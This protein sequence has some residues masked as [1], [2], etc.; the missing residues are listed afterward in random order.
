MHIYRHFFW[1]NMLTLHFFT[2]EI[3]PEGWMATTFFLRHHRRK[4]GSCP[5]HSPS[6]K[7][8]WR[9]LA[10]F[11]P[12]SFW[13]LGAPFAFGNR[14]RW[15]RL[16]YLQ[17]KVTLLSLVTSVSSHET[18]HQGKAG[19]CRRLRCLSSSMCCRAQLGRSSKLRVERRC[20]LWFQVPDSKQNEFWEDSQMIQSSEILCDIIWSLPKRLFSNYSSL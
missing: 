19:S 18:V 13:C 14:G 2:C 20:L 10:V 4:G 6:S 16:L 1:F 9:R 3:Y 11:F 5:F 8:L 12:Q 7:R 15:S 17:E